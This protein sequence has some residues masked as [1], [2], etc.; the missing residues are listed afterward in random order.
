MNRSILI[1]ICDFLVLS[2]MSLSM[3]ISKTTAQGTGVTESVRPVTHLFLIEQLEKAVQ[4]RKDTQGQNTRLN[5]DLEE[6]QRILANLRATLEKRDQRMERLETTLAGLTNNMS[7]QQAELLEARKKADELSNSLALAKGNLSGSQKVLLER[8]IA[9]ASAK[10]EIAEKDESLRTAKM[11]LVQQNALLRVSQAEL[12]KKKAELLKSEKS[13]TDKSKELTRMILEVERNEAMIRESQKRIAEKE[14]ALFRAEVLAAERKTDLQ[15][16]QKQYVVVA[17]EL[18]Q[19]QKK[20]KIAA[21][22]RAYTDGLL[23]RANE[24]IDRMKREAGTRQLLL[25][26]KTEQLAA[27]KVKMA[28]ELTQK[29]M[30]KTTLAERDAQVKQQQSQLQDKERVIT[31][32]NERMKTVNTRLQ[33]KDEVIK[34]TQQ[35]LAKTEKDLARASSM[36]RSDALSSYAKTT[37]Q[38]RFMLKNDRLFN[39]FELDETYYLP[40]I[41]LGGKTFLP[42]AFEKLTGLTEQRNGYSTVTEISYTIQKPGA[43][44]KTAAKLEGPI[45]VLGEDPRACLIELPGD[46]SPA[47]PALT[48]AALRKRGLQN[49]TLFKA[50]RFGEGSASLDG[51]CSMRPNQD[52]YMVI[53]NSL[54][55]SS[56]VPAAVG[57]LVVA[58]EGGLAGIIVRVEVHSTEGRADAYCFIFPSQIDLDKAEQLSWK[59]DA[60]KY[61]YGSFVKKL[62][63]IYKRIVEINRSR[64]E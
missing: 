3:G 8:E 9:L 61:P 1:V 58:K 46:K 23:T 48:A 39:T 4:M 17:A 2:A 37:A 30:L 50:N 5:K 7:R 20:L 18:D 59:R 55:S 31:I 51:R 43:S 34:Q 36:L 19:T 13:L 26:E 57:D 41:S 52:Q 21:E 35:T 32:Q 64:A 53:R 11:T 63:S 38:V 45:L 24:E 15:K 42:G 14:A 62:D 27:I 16:V 49:L 33:A 6:A 56:E 54:R 60:G 29:A 40:R 12:E 44:A 10:K 47:M 28:E 22:D 25:N